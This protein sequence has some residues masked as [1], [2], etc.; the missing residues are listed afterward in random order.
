[1]NRLAPI[2]LSAAVAAVGLILAAAPRGALGG[3]TAPAPEPPAADASKHLHNF[4]R[5]SDHLM[6]GAQPEGDIDFAALAKAGVKVIVSVDGAAPDVEAARKYGLRYV[7]LPIGYDG[8]SEAKGLLLAKA[9]TSI[10]GPF[11]VHCHHGKHRGPAAAALGRL[12]LDHVTPEVAVAEMKR[13][14]T[15]PKYR[16]LYAAPMEFRVPD[17]KA[18]AAVTADLPSVSPVPAVAEAMVEADHKWDRMKAVRAAAWASPKDHPDVDP[19]HEA[20]MLAEWFREMAR[21]PEVVARGETYV[22]A[23]AATENAAWDLSKALERGKS[24]AKAAEV[25]F[26]RVQTS[27]ASCHATHRDNNDRHPA[28]A[29]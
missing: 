16:G 10:E 25:A 20:T 13:A 19:S 29:K 24:D 3:E 6:C 22:A 7:H 15:D 21:R 8:I 18:L 28:A 27:C 5:L 26:D 4:F 14:G 9:F 2:L 17:A 1:M 12:V 23:F 11:F